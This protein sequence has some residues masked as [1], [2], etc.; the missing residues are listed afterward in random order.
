[1][2]LTSIG[3]IFTF[4]YAIK[5]HF[6]STVRVRFRLNKVL[7]PDF[8]LLIESAELTPMPHL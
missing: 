7:P 6:T 5:Q 2:P 4:R 8:G 1:M 3:K